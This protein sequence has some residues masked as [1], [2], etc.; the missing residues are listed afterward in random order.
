M[1]RVEQFIVSSQRSLSSRGKGQALFELASKVMDFG[2]AFPFATH[3]ENISSV[4][5]PL[6]IYNIE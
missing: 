1:P 4:L 2:V 6:G 3:L 5:L